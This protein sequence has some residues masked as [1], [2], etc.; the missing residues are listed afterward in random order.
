MSMT[1]DTAKAART[2]VA[3]DALQPGA[4]SALGRLLRQDRP[5]E[6]AALARAHPELAAALA[7]VKVLGEGAGAAA[8]ADRLREGLMEMARLGLAAAA[9][10]VARIGQSLPRRARRAKRLKLFGGLVAAVSSAGVISALAL[11]Q[12]LAAMLSAGLSLVTSVTALV[13]EHIESPLFGARKSLAELLAEMLAIEKDIRDAEIALLEAAAAP[14]TAAAGA[15]AR[16]A[17]EIAARLRVLELIE[18]IAP[19]A[20]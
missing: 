13:G 7:G 15:L 12:P 18:G 20:A 2:T 10:R 17:N 9:A 19:A 1:P 4:F 16:A 3:A 14:S 8:P 5:E 11:A 6:A